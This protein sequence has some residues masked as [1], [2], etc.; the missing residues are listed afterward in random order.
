MTESFIQGP[1]DGTGKRVRTSQQTI[2]GNAVEEQYVRISPQGGPDSIQF[3]GTATNRAINEWTSLQSVVVPAGFYASP[4]SFRG[5]S[6]TAGYGARAIYMRK[7]GSYNLGTN[8]YTDTGAA[9]SSGNYFSNLMVVVTTALSNTATNLAVS[10]TDDTGAARTATNLALA[11]SQPIASR[12]DVVLGNRTDAFGRSTPIA[13]VRDVTGVAES[14]GTAATGVVDIYGYDI[15]SYL[16]MVAANTVYS[17]QMDPHQWGIP[18][19]DI[20]SVESNSY[21]T[22]VAAIVQERQLL[23]QFTAV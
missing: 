10:F 18:A 7:L 14:P 3:I 6:A 17:E 12:L 15:I 9:A 11:S 20:L 4:L 13:G 8:V 1:V 5:L 2:G 21:A 19:G 23:C 22:A 16:R